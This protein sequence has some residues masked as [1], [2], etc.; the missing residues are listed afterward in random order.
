[1]YKLKDLIQ[2]T[3]REVIKRSKNVSVTIT[4]AIEDL[5]KSGKQFKKIQLKAK[6]PKGSGKTKVLT[7]KLYGYNK[8]ILDDEVWCHC[9]CEYFT[10]N[11]E[12]AL[13]AQDSST[14]I[15]SN[16][17]MP[18]EKNPTMK[19]HFCKHFLAAVNQLRGVKFTGKKN[20]KTT[21]V[22]TE[23]ELLEEL[24]KYKK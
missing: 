17:N 16:G 5:D 9:S 8:N 11:L 22:P 7:I 24:L 1:M 20:Y 14:V 12:V 18:V 6:D 13:T 19:G 2:L 10:F 23:E 21:P 15:N 3:P 4:R